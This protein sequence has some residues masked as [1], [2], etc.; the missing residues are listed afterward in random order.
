MGNSKRTQGSD[1]E[2]HDLRL[3]LKEAEEILE[4]IRE[5][6]VDA[7]VAYEPSGEQ[8]YTVQTADRGYRALVEGMGEGAAILARGDIYYCNHRLAGMLGKTPEFVTGSRLIDYVAPEH[9]GRLDEILR[10]PVA[11]GSRLETHLMTQSGGT[12]PVNMTLSPFSMDGFSGASVLVTDLT[13]QKKTQAALEESRNRFEALAESVSDVFFALDPELRYTYWNRACERLTDIPSRQALGR[14]IYDLFP[15]FHGT[16]LEKTY[17]EVLET[18]VARSLTVDYLIREDALTFEITAYPSGAQGMS[19]IARDV[20]ERQRRAMEI[21]RYTEELARKNRELEDFTS[22]ASHDLQEPLRKIRVFG[23]MVRKEIAE[24]SSPSAWGYLERLT[25]AADRMQQLIKA[26]LSYSRVATKTKPFQRI[27]LRTVAEGVVEEFNFSPDGRGPVIEIGDLPDIEA[28]PVQISQLLQNLVGNAVRYSKE[29]VVP[30]IR[31]LGRKVADETDMERYCELRVE[32]NGIGFDM[33]HVERIFRPFERL[34]GRS[35]YG[36]T[37]MGLA[38]CRKI[39]ERHGGDI[40]AESSPG[41]G[42]TFIIRLP[43]R[44]KDESEESST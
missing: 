33:R 24:C 32:D 18:G 13:D 6:R 44:H 36:G 9:R 2:L 37:G 22:I 15:G 42:S 20:T 28:D 30:G 14:T 11:N 4:A 29:G 25:G 5:G 38:I 17:L 8:V 3:R 39:A 26:L 12:V 27:P 16:R 31:I 40:T 43:V 23:E 35:E 41:K 7:L 19:V 34:H 10:R 1:E 21:Q